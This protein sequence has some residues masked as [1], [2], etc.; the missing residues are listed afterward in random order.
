MS[1]VELTESLICSL[2]RDFEICREV[3]GHHPIYDQDVRVD[4]MCRAKPH[5]A[6]SGFTDQWFG[7][8]CKWIEGLGGQTSKITRMV[9]Q[10]ITYAQSVFN[11]NGVQINPAFVAF[12][13]PDK[14]HP[15]IEDALRPLLALGLYGNIGRL[16]F[17]SD[18]NWGIKFAWSYARSTSQGFRVNKKQLPKKRAGSV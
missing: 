15:N 2:S 18:G 13:T 4:L 8:E 1:E 14:L 3:K 5:L 16:F 10:A 11:I 6:D 17:Y 9:W 12:Y 7:I